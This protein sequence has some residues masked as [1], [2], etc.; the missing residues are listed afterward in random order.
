MWTILLAIL[1]AWLIKLASEI[2]LYRRG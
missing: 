2:V 1:V